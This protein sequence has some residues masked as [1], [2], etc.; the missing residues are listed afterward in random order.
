MKVVGIDLAG[1][2]GRETGFCILRG[3]EATI[4]ILRS[5][6]EILG[7]ALRADPSIVAI[8]A[9]LCLP[10]GR[11]SLQIP[12]GPHLRKCDRDLQAMGIRFFPISL[13]P[14]RRLTERGMRLKEFM[15]SR[16]LRVIEVYPGGAQD[17]LGIPR[18]KVNLK[19]LRDGLEKLGIKNLPEGLNPHELDAVTSAF[20]GK[21]YLEGAYLALGDPEEGLMI[22]PKPKLKSKPSF[23]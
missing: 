17:I 2:E 8:D 23:P 22:M 4:A 16:G 13:G 3:F 12:G 10:K 9:P 7:E 18:A 1:V 6:E 15:E 21:L 11:P 5:D 19:G 14:M 20:V